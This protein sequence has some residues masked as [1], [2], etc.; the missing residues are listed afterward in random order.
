MSDDQNTQDQTAKTSPRRQM[1]TLP[2]GGCVA[3]K[4][5]DACSA[6]NNGRVIIHLANNGFILSPSLPDADETVAAITRAIAATIS[7]EMVPC[8]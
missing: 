3:V 6:Q 1:L 4:A 8:E 5:I 7:V 2:W